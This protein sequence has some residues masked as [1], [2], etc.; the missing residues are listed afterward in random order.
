MPSKSTINIGIKSS[1][2]R[3]HFAFESGDDSSKIPKSKRMSVVWLD[4]A[5]CFDQTPLQQTLCHQVN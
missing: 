1:P 4:N 5:S 2:N 3:M